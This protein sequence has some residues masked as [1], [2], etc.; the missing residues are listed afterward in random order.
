MGIASATTAG[1]AIAT[2]A[3][4]G[5]AD[6]SFAPYVEVATAQVAS[7]VLVTAVLAPLLAAWVLKRQGGDRSLEIAAEAE[8]VA[9]AQGS[10]DTEHPGDSGGPRRATE[11]GA[12]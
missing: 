5:A 3:I 1:N 12:A 10:E 4:V 7:A 11:G 8:A 9:A 2:P 6:P